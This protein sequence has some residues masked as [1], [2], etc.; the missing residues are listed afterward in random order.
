MGP[1]SRRSCNLDRRDAG[2]TDRDGT[3]LGLIPVI[4]LL[5]KEPTMNLTRRTFLGRSA[6]GMGALALASLLKPDLLRGADTTAAGMVQPLHFPPKA[7]RVICLYMAGGPSHLETFDY[8]PKLAAHA[9]PADARV[10]HQGAA[11]RP[12]PGARARTASRRSTRS[13]S[14]ARAARRFARSS[15]T[16]ATVADELCIVRSMQDR[17]DQPRPGPHLHEHRHDHLRPAGDG[18]LARG[19]AWAARART[20]PASSS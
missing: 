14:A 17:G 10:V 15:R 5:K 16:S 20:C 19:T 18:L 6:Y 9:R 11:D 7:K 12:A 1:A 4:W 13:R 3:F 8:K 2:L